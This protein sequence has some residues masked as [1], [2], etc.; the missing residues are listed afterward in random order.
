MGAVYAEKRRLLRKGIGLNHSHRLRKLQFASRLS[1]VHFT[2]STKGRTHLL[3]LPRPLLDRAAISLVFLALSSAVLLL[4]QDAG[5]SPFQVVPR[6]PLS[7]VPLLLIGSAFLII[8]ITSPATRHA[9]LKD[10]LLAGTFWLWGIVQLIPSHSL[11]LRLGSVVIALFV[12]DL[13]WAVMLKVRT[14][15]KVRVPQR[16]TPLQRNC[17]CC[18]ATM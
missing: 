15:G 3:N 7:A 10:V 5:S 6:N 13:A 16:G 12:L 14:E 9:L 2:L 18:K 1:G 8:Q 11:S 4:A 17:D